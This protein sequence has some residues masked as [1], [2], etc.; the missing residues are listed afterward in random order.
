MGEITERL[1]ASSNHPKEHPCFKK[2]SGL[3][4]SKKEKK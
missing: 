4:C 3:A 2:V 1:A